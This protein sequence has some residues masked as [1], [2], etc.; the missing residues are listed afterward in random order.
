MSTRATIKASIVGTKAQYAT[1][2]DSFARLGF[3]LV[4]INVVV[5]TILG[6]I[7]IVAW[8]DAGSG[9]RGG[10]GVPGLS[11]LLAAAMGIPGSLL[12]V[13]DVG[14]GQWRHA[15][16]LLAA[17]GP[18]LIFLG[19]FFGNHLVDPCARGWVDPQSG[20]CEWAAGT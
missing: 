3:W 9:P 8:Q 6:L 7:A 14:R 16:R 20:S 5:S 1:I 13:V 10:W 12:G 18:F 11:L 15:G 4:I 17:A 19:F 2:A